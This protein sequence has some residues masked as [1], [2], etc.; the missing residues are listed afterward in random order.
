MKLTA[1]QQATFKT[2]LTNNAAALSDKDAATLADA[3]ATPAY[4]I[5]RSDGSKM[6]IGGVIGRSSFTPSDAAPASPSTDVTYQNRALLCQ[7][8]QTNAQ[9]LTQGPGTINAQVQQTRQDFKDCLTGIPSGAGGANQ[10]AGWGTAASPGAVR[11]AMMRA[12]TN[13]EK[14]YSVQTGVGNTPGN[15]AADARG[16]STNPDTPGLDADGINVEGTTLV[17]EQLVA[18]TRAS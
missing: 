5:W 11:S 13:F 16:A 4:F 14:L 9:W 6:V 18:E 10:D 1:Q 8:K 2:W 15:Q 7:L 3:A 12:A 17:T